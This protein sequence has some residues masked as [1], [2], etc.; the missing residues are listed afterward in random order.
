MPS[1]IRRKTLIGQQAYGLYQGGSFTPPSEGG[2]IAPPVLS[3][4]QVINITET[5]A[6][7]T[8]DTDEA[9]DSLVDYGLTAGYGS[10]E[11]DPSLVTS[12]S[13]NL[14]GL[15]ENTLYHIRATSE[16]AAN[17]SASTA[18][19]TFTTDAAVVNNALAANEAND[20]A[21]RNSGGF[22]NTISFTLCCWIRMESDTGSFFTIWGLQDASNN[23]VYLYSPLSNG[24]LTFENHNAQTIG[25]ITL[26][27]GV[28]TFIAISKSGT[29]SNQC[30]VFTR[31][32]DDI[33]LTETI[34]TMPDTFTP[35]QEIVLN[36]LFNL[37]L[38]FFNGRIAAVKQWNGVAKTQA[39][40]LTESNQYAVQSTGGLFSFYPMNDDTVAEQVLDQGG[41]A[42]HFTSGGTLLTEEGPPIPLT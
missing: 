8:W 3:N 28:W 5:T 13:I 9:S 37:T 31:E 7:V 40:L 41:S 29:A 1:K 26:T 15:T 35:T 21:S 11:S 39:E 6:T 33:A 36:N 30:R 10:Q 24:V 23:Y 12:H 17:N 42:R 16:D 22:Y 25:S 32:I 4:L 2:D 20:R 27:P 19:D 34:G 18:D 38:G 14:T